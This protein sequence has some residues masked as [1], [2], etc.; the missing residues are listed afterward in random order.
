MYKIE[1]PT[2]S[3]SDRMAV[4]F[5]EDMKQLGVEVSD[6]RLLKVAQTIT[7]AVQHEDSP[8]VTW[9]ARMD[10]TDQVVGLIVAHYF[11]S[12]KFGG[13]ALWIEELYVTPSAR[14]HGVGRALVE[15]L[16]D[17]AETKNDIFGIDLEAYHGNT[18]ASILYR[19]LGFQR[20]GRE[21][22]YYRIR[23]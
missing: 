21:R 19:S 17:F 18:P 3:D 15:H 14:R 20:L 12:L 11:N 23:D 4:L 8:L 10:D 16:L 7:D 22:F 13:K 1:V 5:R 2:I 9:V 6:D